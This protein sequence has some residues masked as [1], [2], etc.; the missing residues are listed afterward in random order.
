MKFILQRHGNC[1]FCGVRDG[2]TCSSE[3]KYQMT[4]NFKIK[5]NLLLFSTLE[6]GFRLPESQ[7]KLS[8]HGN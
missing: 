8:F 4:A 3:T 6:N 7:A 2:D 5:P 1:Q